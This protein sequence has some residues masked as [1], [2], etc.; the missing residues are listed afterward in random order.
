MCNSASEI[1]KQRFKRHLLLREV[2]K[3]GQ[4]KIKNSKVLIVGV[5][6]LGCPIAQYLTAAGVGTIG[7]VDFDRV[8]I[9]NLQRQVLYTENDIGKDKVSAAKATLERL[10]SQITI[11]GLSVKLTQ[12]NVEEIFKDYDIIVDA[13]DNFEA[14]YLI[15]DTCVRL[16]KPEVYG[17]IFEFYGQ[18][19]VFDKTGP[20]LRCLSPTLPKE[21]ELP[22]S[23]DVGVL[24]AVPGVI[25][26]VQA[27]ETLKYI[28]DCK[29]S[30]VGR[31]VFID[32]LNMKFDEMDL[33][34]NEKCPVCNEK[35]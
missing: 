1:D 28:L 17:A 29:K 13:T 20:C 8:D 32:L 34:K 19:T 5:G 25:G 23:K 21:A 12:D 35:R 22:N 33:P 2:G 31:M 11:N 15:N 18:V 14:R 30:L 3:A 24:G 16:E 7:L 6:G 4:I 27:V 10:N 9:S 26:S